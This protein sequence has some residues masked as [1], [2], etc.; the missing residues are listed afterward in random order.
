MQAYLLRFNAQFAVQ[1]AQADP[2]YRRLP[3]TVCLERIV[4]FKYVR[5]VA[6]DN[7]VNFGEHRLQLL[8]EKPRRSYARAEVEVHE[9]LDGSLTEV[10]RS[11]MLAG[12]SS[13]RLLR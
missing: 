5:T 4:C 8:P 10:W 9:R 3:E 1:P 7:T 13:Q 12:V 2:V 11:I 6:L